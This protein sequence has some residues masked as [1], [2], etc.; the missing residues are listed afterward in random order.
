MDLQWLVGMVHL[1]ALFFIAYARNAKRGRQFDGQVEITF[2][3]GGHA[4]GVVLQEDI[5]PDDAFAVVGVADE[6]GEMGW[7]GLGKERSQKADY[8][9]Y[10]FHGLVSVFG[11]DEDGVA[12]H[13]GDGG[14]HATA[15]FH[16]A[17]KVNGGNSAKEKVGVGI[18]LFVGFF[19]AFQVTVA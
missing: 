11:V 1:D 18:Q 2:L 9:K 16:V 15:V 10:S 3:V 8:Q 6:T 7:L 5:G 12:G 14:K 19:F 17:I 13:G 4:F